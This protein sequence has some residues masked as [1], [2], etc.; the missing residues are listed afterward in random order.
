MNLCLNKE[1]EA[2]YLEINIR[3]RKWLFLGLYKPPRQNNSL[4]SENIPKNLL[5]Y[6]DSYE[7][8]ALLGDINMTP[9]DQN[10]QHFTDTFSLERLINEPTC[11][12]GPSCIDLI[13][14]N[15]KSYFKNTCVIVTGIS[16]FHNLTAVSL[17]SQILKASPKIKTYRNYKTFDENRFN[18]DLKS[19]LDS[20]EKLNYPLF[21]N[22]FID[23]SNR[24][25]PVATKKLQAKNHQFMTKVIRKAIMTRHRLKSAYLK[26]RSSKN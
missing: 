24:H 2:T 25:A 9:E 6:L 10:L 1:T 26:I 3:F 15:R 8:I 4:F 19:K 20:I 16:D 17:K 11:F 7:S 23:V 13:I 5:R 22:I 14:T 18:E 21:E 12:K